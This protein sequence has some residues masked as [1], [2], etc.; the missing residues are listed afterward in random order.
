MRLNL[1]AD[2]AALDLVGFPHSHGPAFERVA[3]QERCVIMSR[4]VGEAC[5]QLIEEGYQT[6]GYRIHAKSC[7]WGPMAGFVCLD[8]R[9][10]KKGLDGAKSN[11]NEHM[12]SFA[13]KNVAHDRQWKA[14]TGPIYISDE[15]IQ[16]LRAHGQLGV[17]RHAPTLKGIDLVLGTYHFNGIEPI[18]YALIKNHH[19]I[20]P[21]ARKPMWALCLDTT[22]Y[23]RGGLRQETLGRPHQ[24]S[25]DFGQRYE[26]VMGMINPYADN[27][28]S[29]YSVITG[30]YDLFTVWPMIRDFDPIHEDNRFA[31][32]SS[33]TGILANEHPQLGNITNRVF[34]IAQLL[35]SVIGAMTGLPLRNMCH[36]SDETGRPYVKDVDLPL[37]GFLPDR[38]GK[39]FTYGIRDIEDMKAFTGAAQQLGY[40]VLMNTGWEAQ[41]G[42]VGVVMH[43]N[44]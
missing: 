26:H 8:P 27:P 40:M 22:T 10:N 18:H 5:T 38:K 16:W 32:A 42:K 9:F 24:Y 35:N 14:N 29:P 31:G 11:A 17:P 41:L 19:H 33:N 30:D 39:C 13:N 23:T 7:T 36:H 37:I 3:V 28:R 20:P 4:A 43:R 12:E 15:R 6:K 2:R 44:R 25:R 21:G 1:P 34:L